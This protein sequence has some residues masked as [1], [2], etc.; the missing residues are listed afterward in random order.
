MVRC[1][2]PGSLTE[3]I[4]MNFTSITSVLA[5][6]CLVGSI[7]AQVTP[8][9]VE[10]CSYTHDLEE[11]DGGTPCGAGT[12]MVISC[13]TGALNTG[14]MLLGKNLRDATCRLI[15]IGSQGSWANIPCSMTPPDGAIFVGKL[16][17]GSCCYATVPGPGGAAFIDTYANSPIQVPVCGGECDGG[18]VE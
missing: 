12:S 16:A 14:S 5:V 11:P 17:N 4:K 7:V 10:C 13:E 2:R 6:S 9:I 3:R 1:Q 18:G 8:V 15:D